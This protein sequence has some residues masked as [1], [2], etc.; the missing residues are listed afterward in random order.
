MSTPWRQLLTVVV[1]LISQSV[2][3]ANA[4]TVKPSEMNDFFRVQILGGPLTFGGGGTITTGSLGFK[5][6][7]V[8]LTI[9]ERPDLLLFPGEVDVTGSVRHSIG[10]PGHSGIEFGLKNEPGNPIGFPINL[11]IFGTQLGPMPIAGVPTDTQ[12]G[13][14]P[15]KGANMGHVD[16]FEAILKGTPNR[17]T[18]GFKAYVLTISGSHSACGN[19]FIQSLQ[20]DS[21]STH[22]PEPSTLLLL[23]SGLTMLVGFTLRWHR[24]KQAIQSNRRRI[25][26]SGVLPGQLLGNDNVQEDGRN[27]SGILA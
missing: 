6:W 25:G 14:I 3:E 8:N 16:D 11:Q 23:G 21:C 22:A 12:T 18:A 5:A 15:H 26:A 7:D 9:S 4:I 17:S 1:V 19:P 27:G 10:I 20:S 2:A 13:T 24:R